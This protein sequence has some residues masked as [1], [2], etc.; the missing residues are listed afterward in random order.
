M[1]TRVRSVAFLSTF[2]TVVVVAGAASAVDPTA[3]ETVVGTAAEGA[4]GGFE[5][6]PLLATKDFLNE[7]ELKGPDYQVDG[8]VVNDG[9]MN[10]Y[11]VSATRGRLEVEGTDL[12]LVRLSEIAALQHLEAIKETTTYGEAFATAV[13][14]PYHA[15]KAL[16]TEPV[17]TVKRAGA[18]VGRFLGSVGHAVA[19][20]PTEQE[21]GAVKT[22]LGFDVYKRNFAYEARVDPYTSYVPLVERLNELAWTGFAGGLTVRALFVAVPGP[23]GTTLQATS[24]SEGMRKLVR[25]KSPSELKKHNS[26]V[27]VGMKLDKVLVAAFLDHPKL[28]PTMSTRMV[29]ALAT[30]NGVAGREVVIARATLVQDET[31][32]FYRVRQ[33]EM[34]AAYHAK[35]GKIERVVRIGQGIGLERKDGTIVIVM[36]GDYLAWTESTAASVSA[37][38]SG[39]SPLVGAKEKDLWLGGKASTGAR[40]E[41]QADGWKVVEGARATL[42]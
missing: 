9:L 11:V 38:S 24:F 22:A 26:A 4:D 14:S 18:G 35:V 30:M 15:A 17:E 5:P 27:L 39:D 7:A 31:E 34:I 40:T 25:D 13:K 41:L 37:A 23:I 8:E 33:C 16:V 32:A 42:Q 2:A 10:H 3:H 12:L 28:S 21:D 20:K 1:V 6:T 19:G 36:P 29:G